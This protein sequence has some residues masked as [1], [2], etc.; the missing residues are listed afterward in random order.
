MGENCI[1]LQPTPEMVHVSVESHWYLGII[2]LI[3]ARVH[4]YVGGGEG[5]S[6]SVFNRLV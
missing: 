1:F 6:E 2:V 3:S 5:V 4:I